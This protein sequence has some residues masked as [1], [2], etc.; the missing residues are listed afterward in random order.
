MIVTLPSGH[1]APLEPADLSRLLSCGGTKLELAHAVWAHP[2]L[3]EVTALACG[4]SDLY[5]V[6]RWAIE[7]FIETDDAAELAAV[8]ERLH[9]QPSHRL[10]VTDKV[11]AF[12]LDPGCLVRLEA[13]TEAH[14]PKDAPQFNS[15]GS[16]NDT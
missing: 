8:C 14:R 2:D 11:L 15:P 3:D 6:A 13:V 1:R 9:D 4:G 12:L 10:G 5:Y 7:Q 16:L